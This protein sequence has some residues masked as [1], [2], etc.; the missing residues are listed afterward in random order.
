MR[1][2]DPRH[3]R[4]QRGRRQALLVPPGAAPRGIDIRLRIS[5]PYSWSE[6]GRFEHQDRPG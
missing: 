2:L 3:Q 4:R 6:P 5:S 1:E